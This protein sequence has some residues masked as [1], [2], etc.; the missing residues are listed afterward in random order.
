MW[1]DANDEKVRLEE[2]QRTVRRQREEAGQ[3]AAAEGRTYEGHQPTWF[4][5]EPDL[6]NGGKYV[7]TYRGGYWES[8]EKTDWSKCPDIY[9]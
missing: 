7:F 2:K 5:R 6:Q 1:D 4:K 9:G 8:K 3:A